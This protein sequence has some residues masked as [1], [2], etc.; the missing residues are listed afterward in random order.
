MILQVEAIPK[1]PKKKRPRKDSEKPAVVAVPE[2]AAALAPTTME[3][4]VL[5]QAGEESEDAGLDLSTESGS[6]LDVPLVIDTVGTV[7]KFK[8]KGKKERKTKGK[9]DAALLP[10]ATEVL[11][12]P[13]SEQGRSVVIGWTA[14]ERISSAHSVRDLGGL[15]CVSSWD[16]IS[17]LKEWNVV[18]VLGR[19]L[20][21]VLIV[22]DHLC[23]KT[24]LFLWCVDWGVLTMQSGG[25]HVLCI[26]RIALW[27]VLL[28]IATSE[29]YP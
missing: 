19:I 29:Y 9:V 23:W 6:E 20:L 1:T 2:D 7:S 25:N 11:T 22:R 26:P 4:M 12:S 28:W 13:G 18:V 14:G 27:C 15:W 16:W 5:F 17:Y 3:E 21:S 8:K 24:T 10:V